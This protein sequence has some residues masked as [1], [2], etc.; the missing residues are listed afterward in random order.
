MR[1]YLLPKLSGRWLVVR[2]IGI[3]KWVSFVIVPLFQIEVEVPGAYY[4]IA[5]A[6]VAVK[7]E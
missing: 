5:T 4:T 2:R 1:L 3:R 6:G 7:G